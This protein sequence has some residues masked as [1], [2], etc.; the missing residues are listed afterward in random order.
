MT[1]ASWLPTQLQVQS[2]SSSG[3]KRRV[4]QSR[5][6]VA[7]FSGS[8]VCTSVPNNNNEAGVAGTRTLRRELWIENKLSFRKEPLRR[9]VNFSISQAQE[10]I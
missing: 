5:T 7:S 1:G 6:S 4:G 10:C 3:N 2:N 9:S 8:C